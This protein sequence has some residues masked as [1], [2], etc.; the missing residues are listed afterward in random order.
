MAG[1]S[2]NPGEVQGTAARYASSGDHFLSAG[3]SF[4]TR[5]QL[6]GMGDVFGD[7][8]V[9]LSAYERALQSAAAA[10]PAIANELHGVAQTLAS[11]ARGYLQADLVSH[12][13]IITEPLSE[14]AQPGGAGGQWVS[15]DYRV[16]KK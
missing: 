5:A 13:N 8:N 4:A 9:T 7:C 15:L 2:I 10:V 11:A 6:T 1:I 16:V 14:A 12:D 3:S